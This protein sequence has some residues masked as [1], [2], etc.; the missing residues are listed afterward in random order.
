M[1]EQQEVHTL[2]VLC[3]NRIKTI[4]TNQNKLLEGW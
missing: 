1:Y 3:I 4:N 2:G